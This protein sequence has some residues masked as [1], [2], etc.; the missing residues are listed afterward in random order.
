MVKTWHVF[1][2]K[3]SYAMITFKMFNRNIQPFTK[4]KTK[5]MRICLERFFVPSSIPSCS[6]H[7]PPTN[8]VKML[9]PMLLLLSPSYAFGTW[10][11]PRGLG[12]QDDARNL[13]VHSSHD[14]GKSTMNRDV[15]VFPYFL[16]K[17]G[18]LNENG[19]K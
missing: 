4:H 2:S 12:V 10:G 8:F 17:M 1:F 6:Q 19:D 18:I 16:F 7:F 9:R 3:W 13:D 11:E 5:Q 14:N 15:S